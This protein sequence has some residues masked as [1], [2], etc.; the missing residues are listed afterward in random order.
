[1]LDPRSCENSRIQT[2]KFTRMAAFMRLMGGQ[3]ISVVCEEIFL[4]L[5][6]AK[7]K[8]ER[9]GNSFQAKWD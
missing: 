3:N 6:L 9:Y 1:M 4:K 5:H 8:M 7:E 2:D